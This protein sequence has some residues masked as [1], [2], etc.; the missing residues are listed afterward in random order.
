M[1]FKLTL[2]YDGTDFHG[3]QIQNDL[4]TVQGELTRVLSLIEGRE[5]VVQGSGR[6]DAGVHAEG[7]VASAQL[8]RVITAGKLRSAINGNLKRDVRVIAAHEAADDFHARYAARGKTYLYRIVNAPVISPFWN[9][10][11]HQES[12]PLDL[13]RMRS[14]AELFLGEHDW[15][16]FS[17]AQTEAETRV[18]TVTELAI[19]EHWDER[20]QCRLIEITAT[21]NGFLR[22][23]V[24]SIVGTLLGAARNEIDET[25]I[26]R[27]IRTGERRLAGA[28]APACGLT[29]LRVQ[30]D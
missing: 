8:E 23:M 27:A 28:T 26:Q 30:Y 3:W 2:Q 21:A 20:G 4:R 17:S 25:T 11:A 19:A 7:Q 22:Y 16:A 29:L 10:Y 14:A 15:T 9:R 13:E 6:T 24:R 18:R 5:V 1:N 12:R